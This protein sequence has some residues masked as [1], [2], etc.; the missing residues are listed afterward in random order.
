MN[1]P[2]GLNKENL[3]LIERIL[4]DSL[5]DQDEWSVSV[6]GS[7]RRGD[8]KKYSDLDLWIDSNPTLRSNAIEE[9]KEKF[10]ESDLPI[11]IDLV[12]PETVIPEYCANI[13]REKIEWLRKS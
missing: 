11:K 6:F 5:S 8:H 1:E 3:F 7:R 10:E 4:R 13:S 9:L 12:T 2:L